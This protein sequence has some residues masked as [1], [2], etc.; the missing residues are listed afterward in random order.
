MSQYRFNIIIVGVLCGVCFAFGRFSAPE[1]VRVETKVVTVEKRVEVAEKHQDVVIHEVIRKDGSKVIDSHTVTQSEKKSD[2][3]VAS[4]AS[5]MKEVVKS[6]QSLSVNALIGLNQTY[7]A[8][9]SFPI[10]GPISFG[11]WGLT[12]ASAGVTVGI[13]L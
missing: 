5:E 12:N 13:S 10:L 6:R 11:P 7:G 3:I 1:T 9:V 2:Q 8:L 4:Q